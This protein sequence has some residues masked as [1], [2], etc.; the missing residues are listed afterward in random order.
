MASRT[1]STTK[2]YRLFTIDKENR[3]LKLPEHRRLKKSMQ[4]YGFLR[5]FPVVCAR[6]AQGDLIVKD[7]Q[8]RL[9]FAEELGL[10]VHYIV[11]EIDFDIATINASPKSW[12]VSDYAQMHAA[13]GVDDYREGLEF[14]EKYR[15]PVG[16]AFAA[17]A[18]TTCM[19]NIS[20][21]FK[22]GEFTVKDRAY[23]ELVG[24]TF[25]SIVK[26]AK[27]VRKDVFLKAIMSVCRVP[28]FDAE[29][30]INGVAGSR[31]KLVSYSTKDAYLDVLEEL[32]NR[33]RQRPVALKFEALQAMRERNPLR[34]KKTAG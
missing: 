6:S 9:A 3:P 22:R 26:L 8:H 28:D 32:Y 14:A 20:D 23:A 33:R 21:R 2:N 16:M 34:K 11:E 29:R 13:N 15:I 10:A 19:T 5:S 4:M 30:L 17:L 24:Y 12:S 1:I 27:S 18:G 25:D 31:E 7:G